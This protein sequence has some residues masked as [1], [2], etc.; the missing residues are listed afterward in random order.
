MSERYDVLIK[1]VTIVDG[2]GAPG[3]PGDIGILG[4][5]IAAVGDV[6]GS[7]AQ[8]LDG[9]GLIASPGF[10][11]PHSHAD[12][13]IMACPQGD[14]LLM[15]GI[16]TFIGGNCA[17]SMAPMKDTEFVTALL[18]EDRFE[19][20]WRTFKEWLE[21]VEKTSI[22]LNYIPL[23]GH[24]NLRIAA[25]GEDFKRTA[26]A[27]EIEE[28]KTYITEAMQ[29]GAWGFSTFRDPG[30]SEYADFGELVAL[31]R[32]V[33]AHQ[34]FF[35]PHTYF[36]Q[37]QWP[38][39]DLEEMGYGIYHGPMEDVYVGRYRGYLE[40]IDI[41]RQTGVPVH[42]AHLS[43]AHIIPEPHPVYLQ[44][45]SA[46]ATL[47]IIDEARTDGIDVTFDV[48]AASSSIAGQLPL[49]RSFAKW[50]DL[51]LEKDDLVQQLKSST[52]REEVYR[53]Q[54][55]G[56]L[57]FGMVHT[58]A[59]PYWADCFMIL[60]C[61]NA[62]YCERIV[63]DI[64][65]DLKKDPVGT[66]MDILVEDPD[67]TWVQYMDKRMGDESIALFLNHP[68]GMPCTDTITVTSIDRTDHG[69]DLGYG[70]SPI[71]FGLYPHYFGWFV[72]QRGDLSLEEAVRKAT[73]VPAERF[74]IE[75]RGTLKA[76]N[77]ADIVLFALEKMQ[78][79]G[80]FE[81]PAQIPGGI[82][83]VLV[84]GEI[85]YQDEKHTGARPGKVIRKN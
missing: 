74:G 61:K 77:Y 52:L 53:T 34:G 78:M 81:N 26:T 33:H 6:E 51:S 18:G 23:V 40:V 13:S 25:M 43:L 47:E 22:S 46:R 15:Q 16:T 4:E 71:M 5:R 9:S 59:D 7:A 48:I 11:D 70:L 1:N 50:L 32:V 76:G 29:S 12:L 72:R 39:D 19:I 80:D 54:D 79:K 14:N 30:P 41:G 2:S 65:R 36:I 10:I 57:K 49:I 38:S 55:I 67:T 63:A 85:V 37:S 31:N 64:A 44:E 17:I 3:Y 82:S 8:E 56:R 62:D 73:S 35:M 20:T 45:A 60:K 28:M 75:D 58:K 27:E 83:C 66:L 42:I 69:S 24:H 84:N 21:T 68:Q